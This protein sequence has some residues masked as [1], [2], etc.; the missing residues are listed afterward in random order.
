MLVT[1]CDPEFLVIGDVVDGSGAPVQHAKVSLVC[2]GVDQ[3]SDVS[4]DTGKFKLSTTGRFGSGCSI[5]V[6]HERHG[7]LQADV[8]QNCVERS[9]GQCATV[10][11]HARFR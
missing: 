7:Q 5:Q 9:H 2:D 6:R 10:S 4:D 8:M 11:L 1:A 3:Y